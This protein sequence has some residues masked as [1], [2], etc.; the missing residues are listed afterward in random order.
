MQKFRNK[1]IKLPKIGILDNLRLN[2]LLYLKE[3]F[4]SDKFVPT[5]RA[6]T[7]KERRVDVGKQCAE[8]SRWVTQGKRID[9]IPSKI[10]LYFVHDLI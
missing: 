3:I 4:F 8:I 10:C 9:Y 2:L 5:S 1:F 7:P 6:E